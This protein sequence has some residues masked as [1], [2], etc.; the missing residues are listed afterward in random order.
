MTDF[1]IP[2]ESSVE[3]PEEVTL[4]PHV[5]VGQVVAIEGPKQTHELQ[6]ECQEFTPEVLDFLKNIIRKA[7][8]SFRQGNGNIPLGNLA[9]KC[10]MVVLGYGHGTPTNK[11][12]HTGHI[13]TTSQIDPSKLDTETLRA[14]VAARKA[15]ER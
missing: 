10:S 11:N 9:L 3:S 1:H 8:I 14:I 2:D 5:H 15:I 13:T 6:R 7:T 4:E 12:E